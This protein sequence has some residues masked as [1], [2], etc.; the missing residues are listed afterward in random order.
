VQRISPVPLKN[1]KT[2]EEKKLK[3]GDLAAVVANDEVA[4]RQL[5]VECQLG[6]DLY[7]EQMLNRGIDPL[8]TYRPINTTALVTAIEYDQRTVTELIMKHIIVVSAPATTRVPKKEA[9]RK[10]LQTALH[11]CCVNDRV[12]HAKL[13]L[14]SGVIPLEDTDYC[15]E[16]AATNGSLPM[17]E[18]L[19]QHD[20][21][22]KKPHRWESSITCSARRGHADVVQ[23]LVQTLQSRGDNAAEWDNLGY[24]NQFIFKCAAGQD[25]QPELFRLLKEVN[26]DQQQPWLVQSISL[27]YALAVCCGHKKWAQKVMDI[28]QSWSREKENIVY[29]DVS[30]E[31]NLAL[32][33]SSVLNL[34]NTMDRIMEHP[35]YRPPEK[36][37]QFKSPLQFA[38]LIDLD[39]LARCSPSW[40]ER[41]QPF[42]K[43]QDLAEDAFINAS[44]CSAVW[45]VCHRWSSSGHPDVEIE[46]DQ[47]NQQ[48]QT[49]VRFLQQHRE[50]Y[51]RCCRIRSQCSEH[52]GSKLSTDRVGLFYDFMSLPQKPR[53]E[54][55]EHIFQEGL[56]ELDCIATQGNFLALSSPHKVAE[57][58]HRGWCYVEICLALDMGGD[59]KYSYFIN[60][61]HS[62][63]EDVSNVVFASEA[64]KSS[65]LAKQS[66]MAHSCH[67]QE[68]FQSE[69]LKCTN[70]NDLLTLAS[71]LR[72][73]L[74]KATIENSRRDRSRIIFQQITMFNDNVARQKRSVSQSS[75]DKKKRFMRIKCAAL[76][77]AL[78]RF[79]PNDEIKTTLQLTTTLWPYFTPDNVQMYVDL[80]NILHGEWRVVYDTIFCTLHVLAS[81]DTEKAFFEARE[82]LK[83]MD[84]HDQ[85]R[86]LV[87]E[88]LPEAALQLMQ[89]QAILPVQT[90]RCHLDPGRKLKK[91]NSIIAP[92]LKNSSSILLGSFA[93]AIV[94]YYTLRKRR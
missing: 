52:S 56:K 53:S 21:H 50:K 69:G 66:R 17:V 79:G 27:G 77:A 89:L 60:E 67:I 9:D 70:E 71:V 20:S 78:L 4:L 59:F 35:V 31:D 90:I 73:H 15:L 63:A 43:C 88:L 42:P 55:Q 22:V 10:A 80:I 92:A 11:V 36:K 72:L 93:L 26:T 57:F 74:Q 82:L 37:M 83:S 41:R 19:L 85:V 6:Q 5:I 51:C 62:G 33:A 75:F 81:R 7:V 13:L 49:I 94:A 54:Q 30:T 58:L 1:I 18:Y 64:L 14:N 48:L 29:L 86:L 40:I 3:M 2:G 32:R 34:S 76:S 39:W 16:L 12:E 23:L 91:W 25:A 84:E 87:L 28:C 45:F 68:M 8:T 38:K 46:S 65:R 44:E 61:E 24:R 47:V